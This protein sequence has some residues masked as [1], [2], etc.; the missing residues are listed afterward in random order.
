MD[1]TERLLYR[2][3]N[4]G[5]RWRN[6]LTAH[7][8]APLAQRPGSRTIARS[9]RPPRPPSQSGRPRSRSRTRR[10]SGR[11]T[12]TKAGARPGCSSAAYFFGASQRAPAREHSTL[13]RPP[14]QPRSGIAAQKPR[15][16]CSPP[17]ESAL[18]ALGVGPPSRSSFSCCRALRARTESELSIACLAAWAISTCQP[19]PSA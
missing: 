1:R 12:P 3:P 4:G 14:H 5:I 15:Y 18:R 2:R 13:T 6:A 7:A 8:I 16:P 17:N 11:S 10:R 9:L 19:T